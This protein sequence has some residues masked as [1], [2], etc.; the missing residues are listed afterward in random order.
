MTIVCGDMNARLGRPTENG[1][2]TGIIGRHGYA[3]RELADEEH[4]VREKRDMLIQFCT[5]NKF[6]VTNTRLEKPNT[7]KVTFRRLGTPCGQSIG[8]GRYEQIDFILLE[9]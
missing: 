6:I 4:E 1:D 8:A 5:L 2:E 7:E 9:A 3:E